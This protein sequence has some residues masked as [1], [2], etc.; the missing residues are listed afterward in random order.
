MNKNVNLKMFLGEGRSLACQ[1]EEY[2][3]KVNDGFN[4]ERFPVPLRPM[5]SAGFKVATGRDIHG[6]LCLKKEWMYYV[7]ELAAGI[8]DPAAEDFF[9]KIPEWVLLFQ[10]HLA[11]AKRAPSDAM[12]FF[13]DRQ[14]IKD[15]EDLFSR[16]GVGLIESILDWFKQLMIL[17]NRELSKEIVKMSS[18]LT[19]TLGL[20]QGIT[21]ENEV[22]E[23][24]V[25]VHDLH[26]SY[27]STKA[28]NGISFSV[29]KGEV[30]G[31]LGPN[32]AGKT[33]LIECIEGIRTPDSGKVIILGESY[34]QKN[35]IRE[36]IGIQLQSTGFFP[37]LTVK[38]TVEMYASFFKKSLLSTD[39][40]SK[41]GLSGKLSDTV[42][43]LSGGQC[44]RLSL[45]VA[46]VND[47]EILFL[48]EPSTG[49]DP[50]AR[51]YVWDIVRELKDK[52][53]TIFVTTHYMEEAERLC[54]RLAIIDNG[55]IIESGSPSDL[56]MKHIGEKSIEFTYE[57]T[58]LEAEILEIPGLLNFW[59]KKDKI[60]VV[61]NNEREALLMLASKGIPSVSIGD[62]T[63][64]RGTLEDV[65]LKLTNR[66]IET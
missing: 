32:G 46:L 64:R 24:T 13:Q 4:H 53:K 35:H 14:S 33:T 60:L 62:I 2:L 7:D 63:I 43:N 38:E 66:G 3:N 20:Q 16:C 36:K 59:I 42:K 41:V 47:P 6:W 17:N 40:I 8:D 26:K 30:F 10:K 22:D 57:G 50:Q 45:A 15:A 61:S 27:G 12:R 21:V 54:D 51:Q 19:A 18:N 39:V 23:I 49:L 28:V 1:F 37:S 52:G 29:H 56:I 58:I 31:L 44:Q 9:Q 34:D 25:D 11:F 5:A 65:F 55:R 48:D